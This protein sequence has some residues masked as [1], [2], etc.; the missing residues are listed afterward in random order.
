MLHVIRDEKEL[1]QLFLCLLI[2]AFLFCNKGNLKAAWLVA[3]QK[4]AYVAPVKCVFP[5]IH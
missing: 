5:G 2:K 4:C 1:F 3:I